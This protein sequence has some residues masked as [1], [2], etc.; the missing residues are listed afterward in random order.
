MA[1]SDPIRPDRD[2]TAVVGARIWAQVVDLVILFVQTVVVAVALVLVVR[3]ATESG[4]RAL[5]LVTFLILPLYGG[6][7][8][9]YWN[10]QTVGKRLLDIK[11]VDGRGTDPSVGQALV[12]NLP[13]VVLFSW[14][15]T[16]VALAA[17][18][19]SDRRQR[20]F[21]EVANTYV[22]GITT[23]EPSRPSLGTESRRRGAS[24]RQ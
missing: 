10:G 23:A 13:A 8:E 12:R 3:P 21:D 20:V 18:A 11:V 16:A 17:I 22:V 24:R 1:S 14:L 15:T 9:G 6:L 5:T 7:L 4:V 19:I 2:T